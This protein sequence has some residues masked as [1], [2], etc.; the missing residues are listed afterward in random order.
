MPRVKQFNEQ[1]VLDKAIDLFWKQGY[2]ATSVQDLVDALGINRASLYDTFGNKRQLFE[3]ALSYYRAINQRALK[4]FLEQYDDVREGIQ[5]FFELAFQQ[6]EDSPE[7]RGCF[8]VNVT[9]EM[10]PQ[11]EIIRSM[12]LDNQTEIEN[13]FVDYLAQGQKK[14]QIAADKDVRAVAS[15]L[16]VLYNGLKVVTKI[17]VDEKSLQASLG[18]VLGLLDV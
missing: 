18:A 5:R 6:R 1:E 15:L 8:V 9:A 13:L 16:F 3:R 14:G 11:D 7:N 10:L 17:Q 4:T 2:H 12:L